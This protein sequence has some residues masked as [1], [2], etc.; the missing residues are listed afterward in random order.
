MADTNTETTTQDAY[1][2]NTPNA[3]DTTQPQAVAP[4]PTAT[5]PGIPFPY[6][7][8]DRRIKDY[9]YYMRLLMGQHFEAFNIRIS[10]EKYT[11]EY[12]KLRYVMANIAAL[13]AKVPAD[14]LFSEPPKFK[15]P[16]DAGKDD[17]KFIDALVEENNLHTQNYESAVSNAALGDAL[18]KIRVGPRFAGDKEST[19]IIEDITPSIYFP[20]VDG[21][22]V[23]S[24]PNKQELAWTFWRGKDKYLR[25]EIHTPGKIVNEVWSMEAE[26]IITKQGL[27]LVGDPELKDVEDTKVTR[28]L[29]VHI[30][31]WKTGN[32]YFGISDYADIDKLIYAINNRLTKVDNILDKH[33]D[34]ILMVPP[35]VLDEKGQVKKKSL[36]VIE[37]GEGENGKP[38]YV[39]WDASLENAFKELEKQMEMLFMVS[40]ISPDILG[41]G[42]GQSDSGRA[43]KLKILRTIAKVARKRLYYDR[44]LKEVFYRAMD[45]ARAWNVKV[46]GFSAPVKPFYPEIEWQDGIPTI[47]DEQ[48]EIE[49]KRLDAGNTSVVDSIMRLD[50]LSQEEAEAKAK[51]IREETALSMPSSALG[52]TSFGPHKTAGAG[53]GNAN[54]TSHGAD[55]GGQNGK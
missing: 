53:G 10:D 45:V 1:P 23:R 44:G 27:W 30:P 8:A 39:V 55:A 18:Y 15:A 42:Q 21:F 19:V 13:I 32:R 50:G 17:Q 6:A 49:A 5:T 51:E 28:T 52:T 11:R 43:L 48:V 14:M 3:V 26:K 41:M 2:T 25:K 40:E 38:E 54:A 12:S 37:V 35:G 9:A 47:M 16:A 46:G 22:N 24:E 20:G 4:V 36:G 34:P 7:N 31:N 29:L 33:S